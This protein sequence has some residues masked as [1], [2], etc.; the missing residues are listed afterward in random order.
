MRR[1]G[2]RFLVAWDIWGGR[3]DRRV[4]LTYAARS[5]HLH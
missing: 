1:G 5:I 3:R 2:E 4:K